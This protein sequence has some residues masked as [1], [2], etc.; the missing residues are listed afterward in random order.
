MVFRGE[1][2]HNIGIIKTHL[3]SVRTAAASCSEQIKQLD[4]NVQKVQRARHA[5][6]TDAFL[7]LL[8]QV[9]LGMRTSPSYVFTFFL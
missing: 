7:K 9:L 6:P 5:S 8:S 1:L 2:E 4:I 3:D